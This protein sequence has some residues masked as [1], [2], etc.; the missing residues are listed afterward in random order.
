MKPLPDT[1]LD[2][3]VRGLF[4]PSVRSFGEAT[5]GM[6]P[7]WAVDFFLRFYHRPLSKLVGL[8]GTSA[9]ECASGFGHAALGFLL[10]GGERV[11]G[12]D[13]TEERVRAA[14]EL[15]TRLGLGDRA[16]FEVGDIH[17]LPPGRVDV[18]ITLQTLEHVPRPLD[19]LSA[20]ASRTDRAVLLS[21][22]NR[23][24]PKDGHDSG[25]FFAHWLPRGA[26]RRWV[27][28]MRPDVRVLNDFLTP[29]QI[30]STLRGFRRATVAYNFGSVEEWLQQ[31]PCFFPY[32]GE[33]RFLP[34][35]SRRR[36]W[37]AAAAA[38][39]ILGAKAQYLAPMFEGIY[40]RTDFR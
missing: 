30:E 6:D 35:R 18:T 8:E 7:A 4:S 25:L 37:R 38:F 13:R 26:R 11:L 22:P 2:P 40:V 9:L 23:L 28:A 14:N 21:T 31:F 15:A 19:A 34:A 3:R 33:G 16:R 32:S 27:A 5:S 17:D 1:D 20:L 12:I 10:A 24:F 39:R 29:M 36:R